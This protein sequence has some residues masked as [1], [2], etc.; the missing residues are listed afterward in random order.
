MPVRCDVW[1]EIEWKTIEGPVQ[2]LG[3]RGLVAVTQAVAKRGRALVPNPV[4]VLAA[5][6]IGV[7]AGTGSKSGWIVVPYSMG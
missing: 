5:G 3:G 1:P 2:P 4:L 7:T 6:R